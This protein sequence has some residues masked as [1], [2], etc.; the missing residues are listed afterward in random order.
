MLVG[1]NSYPLSHGALQSCALAKALNSGDS[2]FEHSF[3]CQQHLRPYG[4]GLM[5]SG[6]LKVLRFYFLEARPVILPLLTSITLL[7]SRSLVIFKLNL[8]NQG[9]V[10]LNG[11]IN[12]LRRCGESPSILI[13]IS[14]TRIL[15][16]NFTM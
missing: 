11:T 1:A 12:A 5:P 9:S 6:P 16:Q 10:A 14:L 15:D 2:R 4:S 3:R 13:S 7:I 8:Q